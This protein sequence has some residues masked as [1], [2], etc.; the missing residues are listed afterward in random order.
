MGFTDRKEKLE[1]DIWYAEKWLTDYP[2][3]LKDLEF[4]KKNTE[5]CLHWWKIE[6][7]KIKTDN[8]PD[9]K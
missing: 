3:I 7:D 9:E 6:L 2:E 8:V 5:A 1:S 4:Y